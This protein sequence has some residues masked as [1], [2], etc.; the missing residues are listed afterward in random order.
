MERRRALRWLA[1]RGIILSLTAW[2]LG[3]RLDASGSGQDYLPQTAG[4]G[5]PIP[6]ATLSPTPTR[7]ATPQG[8]LGISGRVTWADAPGQPVAGAQVAVSVCL[9]RQPFTTVTGSDGRYNLTIPALY[10]NTCAQ[11]TIQVTA[12]GYTPYSQVVASAALRAQPVRDVALERSTNLAQV[13][14]FLYQLQGMDL[15]AIGETAYDLV[16]IDYSR[17]GSVWEEF[18]PAEIAALQVSAGGP[19]IVLSYL[20]IGEAED[21]RFY[22]QSGWRPGNPAWLDEENPDWAGNYKV[23]YWDPTWQ[24]IIYGYLD[25]IVAA[26]FD[27]AYLD[28]VDAYAY[29]EEQGRATAAQEM[30]DFVAAIAARAR[31]SNPDFIIVAQNAPELATL[32]TGYLDALDG[33]GQEDLYYG[34][35]GDDVPT[36]AGI[37]ALWESQLNVF[38]QAGK[39][40]FTID[41]ATQIE[42]IDDA[43]SRSQARGYV[44]FCTVRALDQLI[45]NPGHEPD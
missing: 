27:G 43:Y 44:P 16:V 36:P 24:A 5:A 29:Y 8:D 20:S 25:R 41:Y 2:A 17:D 40:V 28:L 33:I 37:T 30:A 45:I 7:T 35:A 11:L 6:T 18:S 23:H 10:L 39:V 32:T 38:R 31:Q 3:A 4:G 14:D 22:W 15:D 26:G 34:Y 9:P 1:M 19:K 42:F 13:D 21:Y 12:E